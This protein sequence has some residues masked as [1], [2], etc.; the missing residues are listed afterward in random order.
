M[1]L[2][3]FIDDSRVLRGVRNEPR[4]LLYTPINTEL[5]SSTGSKNT[6]SAKKNNLL[7]EKYH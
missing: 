4:V 2:S 6:G 7:R 5:C 1:S 3:L